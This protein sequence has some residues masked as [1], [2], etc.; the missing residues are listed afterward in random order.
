MTTD[1][2]LLANGAALVAAAK[3]LAWLTAIFLL[4]AIRGGKTE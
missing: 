2:Y 1:Q 3:S 4:I